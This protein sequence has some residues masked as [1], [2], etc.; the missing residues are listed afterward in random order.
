MERV[1]IVSARRRG[2]AAARTCLAYAYSE[3][4]ARSALEYIEQYIALPTEAENQA[5]RSAFWNS[6]GRNRKLTSRA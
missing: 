4:E 5:R 6:W 1:N 2:E 3:Q